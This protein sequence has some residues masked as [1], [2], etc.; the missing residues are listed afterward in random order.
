MAYVSRQERG[1]YVCSQAL[2]RSSGD[3]IESLEDLHNGAGW[4]IKINLDE[5]F[6]LWIRYPTV[7][8]EGTRVKTICREML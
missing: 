5:P 8:L 2:L 7:S 3:F 6:F 1:S 4:R